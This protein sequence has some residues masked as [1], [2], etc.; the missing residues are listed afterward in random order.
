MAARSMAKMATMEA[1]P[2]ADMAMG[3]GGA[4]APSERFLA[5]SHR[6]QVETPAADLAALWE[7]VK[8][9]CERL[10]CYVEGSQLRRET[11]QSAAEA[12]LAMRVSPQDFAALTAS[13]GPACST[14]RPRPRTRPM[15]WSMWRHKSRT[16]RNTATACAR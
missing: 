1:A 15:R 9:R 5:I 12:M 3:Q 11:P 4:A 7:E 14:T 10:D 2:A 16:A 8:A 6:I 13:L